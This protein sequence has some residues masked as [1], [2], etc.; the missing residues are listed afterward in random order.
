MEERKTHR[1]V[2]TPILHID[3]QNGSPFLRPVKV[4]LPLMN[5]ETLQNDIKQS[6]LK[7]GDGV[8]LT[9]DGNSIEFQ[10]TKFSPAFG[11]RRRNLLN[12]FCFTGDRSLDF[13]TKGVYFIAKQ[14][15]AETVEIDLRRFRS[16]Q[17]HRK[18]RMD[19]TAVYF[20][21]ANPAAVEPLDHDSEVHVF[22][23]DVNSGKN[24][25]TGFLEAKKQPFTF[26]QVQTTIHSFI[27]YT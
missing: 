9:E 15:S 12:A 19:E 5:Y 8:R 7:I 4:T 11:V 3:R 25:C 23:S 21:A 6:K 14:I 27:R 16:W 26:L 20:A 10:Q 24:F 1:E 18:Y 2:V 13:E 17:E 22:I